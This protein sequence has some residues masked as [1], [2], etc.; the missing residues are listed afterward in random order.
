[1]DIREPIK[2]V[3]KMCGHAVVVTIHER[4]DKMERDMAE[5]AET[6]TSLLRAAI[7]AAEARRGAGPAHKATAAPIVSGEKASLTEVDA[8]VTHIEINDHHGVGVLLG[9][10]FGGYR[11]VAS[12]RS[13]NYYEGRQEF[14]AIEMCVAEDAADRLRSEFAGTRVK[15]ILCAPYF[16]QDARNALALREISGARLCTY[17]MDDQNLY[18]TGLPDDLM[19]ELLAKSDLR[20]AISPQLASAYQEKY[21]GKMWLLPPLAPHRFLLESLNELPEEALKEN[22]GVM[23]GNIWGSRWVELL[24][25]TVRDSGIIL[26]WYNHGEFRGLPCGIEALA[27]DGIMAQV[28][29]DASDENL[30]GILRRA[31]F[32]VLPSG[33]LDESDDRR[34]IAQLSLPSRIPYIFATSHAPILVLGS[35]ETAAARFVTGHGIGMAAP[36]NRAGFQAAVAHITRPDV[37]LKKR[38]AAFS[39]AVRFSDLGAAEWIWR[40][41]EK[42]AAADGRYEDL[43]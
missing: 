2:R 27:A 35:P 28:G 38:R 5:L 20:L 16:P 34:F 31:P 42:G 40:S 17:L 12:I 43:R 30:T 15:R 29:V 23:V 6:Q 41:L 26:R 21:G 3:L 4:L 32:V 33:V 10:M 36:Y 13:Q 24:R 1:M 37:N 11:D 19:K 9:R 18:A 22:S 8:I 14:G 7:D 39:L 25:E